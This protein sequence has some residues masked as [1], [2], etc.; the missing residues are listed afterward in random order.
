MGGPGI[1]VEAD[2]TFIG[3]K[4]KMSDNKSVVLE[5]LSVAATF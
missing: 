3:G 1:M 2:E 5:L 4:D